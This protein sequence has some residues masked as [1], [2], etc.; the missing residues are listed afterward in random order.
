MISAQQRVY[1]ICITNIGNYQL[2]KHPQTCINTVIRKI[3]DTILYG[4]TRGKTMTYHV[5]Y[6]THSSTRSRDYMKQMYQ[7]MN[8][9]EWVYCLQYKNVM[10]RQ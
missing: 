7:H 1:Y 3:R 6:Y 4:T 8:S 2:R 10:R 9:G 5:K